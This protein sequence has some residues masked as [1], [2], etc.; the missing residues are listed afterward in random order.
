M[1]SGQRPHGR[2]AG[3]RAVITG[4]AQGIGRESALL[5]AAEGAAVAVAD[6]DLARATDV[7]A[8]I[9]AAGGTAVPLGLDVADDAS[10]ATC[11]AAAEAALGGVDTL[12][13]NAGIMLESDRGPEDTSLEA[14]NR[15]IAVDLTG[16]FLCCRHGVPALLRGGGG[17]ILNMSSMVALLGSAAPNLAYVA[18]KGGVLSMT[19]EIAVQYGRSGIR[20]NAILP[21]PIATDLAERLFDTPQKLERRRQHMPLGRFGKAREVAEVACFLL[22]DAASYV[23][24]AGWVVDGGITSAYITAEDPA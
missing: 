8:E 7:A 23:T 1:A 3:R 24:G 17:A 12:F 15:T 16:V 14:W 10:V 4:A 5:F 9:A 19:K 22:S 13:N 2:L 11:I 21:G 18:A 20:C 6:L